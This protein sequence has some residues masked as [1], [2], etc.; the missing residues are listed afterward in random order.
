MPAPRRLTA[1]GQLDRADEAGEIQGCEIFN[2][3]C[4]HMKNSIVLMTMVGVFAMS[5][6]S[7][8][9]V[10]D[11]PPIEDGNV[12]YRSHANIVEAVKQDSQEVLWSTELYKDVQPEHYKPGVEVDIQWNIIRRLEKV[13]NEIRAVDGKG[14][15]YFLNQKTGRPRINA[16]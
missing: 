6:I 12:I 7:Y 2:R 1:G 11:P 3:K 5:S 13:G 16:K 9:K 8:G 14:R 15:E 10:T 4:G